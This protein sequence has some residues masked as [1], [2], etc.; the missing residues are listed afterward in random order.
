MRWSDTSKGSPRETEI[1]K[2]SF[3][4]SLEMFGRCSSGLGTLSFWDNP[5]ESPEKMSFP[6]ENTNFTTWSSTNPV[7]LVVGPHCWKWIFLLHHNRIMCFFRPG[8]PVELDHQTVNGYPSIHQVILPNLV[9]I[10]WEW[11]V[12]SCGNGDQWG[13]SSAANKTNQVRPVLPHSM[14]GLDPKRYP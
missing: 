6:I 11:G 7:Q 14:G 12:P 2:S 3:V 9:K 5:E 10:D 1:V 13:Q 4:H 8:N